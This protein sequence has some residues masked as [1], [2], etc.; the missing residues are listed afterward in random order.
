MRGSL[1]KTAGINT[2]PRRGS[3]SSLSYVCFFAQAK[4]DTTAGHF[5]LP[6]IVEIEAPWIIHRMI[7]NIL[8]SACK[9]HKAEVSHDF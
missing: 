7:D 8:Y 3:G 5:I 1:G 4:W 9:I 2:S 6:A